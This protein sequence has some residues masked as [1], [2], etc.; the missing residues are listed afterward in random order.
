MEKIIFLHYMTVI[1][2]FV[3]IFVLYH[4]FFMN[5]L[6][7]IIK[8]FQK[9]YQIIYFVIDNKMF[10]FPSMNNVFSIINNFNFFEYYMD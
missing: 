8:T 4:S 5:Y 3:S 10:S 2:L 6:A 7:L 1:E 9:Y